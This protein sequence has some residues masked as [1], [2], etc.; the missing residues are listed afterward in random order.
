MTNFLRDGVDL[1]ALS[2]TTINGDAHYFDDNTSPAKVRQNL[3]SIKVR[4]MLI[5]TVLITI[6]NN[7]ITSG[8]GQVERNEMVACYDFQ[9]EGRV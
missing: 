2:G 6:T 4:N 8:I 3:D 7:L 5:L 9:G 1:Q